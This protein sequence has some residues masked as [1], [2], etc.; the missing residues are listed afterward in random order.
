[1]TIL[2]LFNECIS[3]SAGWNYIDEQHTLEMSLSEKDGVQFV[4]FKGSSQVKDWLY[5]F[6]AFP[7]KFK[8]HLFH[9]GFLMGMSDAVRAIQTDLDP[10]ILTIFSG[11]SQGAARATIAG[12]TSGFKNKKVIT[13]AEPR[14]EFF[15]TYFSTHLK[16]KRLVHP[17]DPVPR[18]PPKVL[19]YLHHGK[20]LN[21]GSIHDSK[22]EIYHNPRTYRKYLEN[23]EY[24]YRDI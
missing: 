10:N 20:K 16:S 24:G 9:A 14:S 23:S 8:K 15:L 3:P 4:F 22:L 7:V 1:M 13:F 17:L 18:V 12:I 2:S 6:T 19:G 21:I 5:N 11:F